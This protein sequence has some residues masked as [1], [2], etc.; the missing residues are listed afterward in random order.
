MPRTR[1]RPDAISSASTRASSR[2]RRPPRPIPRRGS[3]I[4]LKVPQDLSADAPSASA[5]PRLN[6]DPARRA[7]RS[8]RMPLTARNPARTLRHVSEPKKRR[9]CPEDAKIGTLRSRP[10]TL[11][12]PLPGYRLSGR[13]EAGRTLPPDHRRR[14][15]QRSRQ[16]SRHGRPRPARPGSW[17]SRSKT[18]RSSRSRTSTC[19]SSVPS[20]GASPRPRNAGPSRSTAPSLRGTR[21]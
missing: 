21:F 2:S 15:L 19:T 4:D 12:G 8:T 13:T 1:R 6:R 14:R 10:P 5:D 18:C 11:P 16:A 9:S 17:R 7:S 20:A 3:D